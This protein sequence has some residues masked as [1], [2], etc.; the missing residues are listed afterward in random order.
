MSLPRMN[1]PG[2]RKQSGFSLV[3]LL[4][5]MVVGLLLL[6]GILEILLGNREGFE[7]QQRQAALQQNTR[8]ASFV[9]SNALAPTG[10]YVDGQRDENEVFTNAVIQ[11]TDGGKA[12]EPDELQI[13]FQAGG[14]LHNCLGAEIGTAT[15]AVESSFRYSLDTGNNELQCTPI[16]P[17]ASNAQPLV[18]NVENLQIEYGLDSDGDGSADRYVAADDALFDQARVVSLHLQLVLASPGDVLT[19]SRAQTLS[20]IGGSYTVTDRRQRQILD[21]TIALKNR[22]L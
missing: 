18:N 14:D 19:E 22:L 13:R 21:M 4:V 7:V 20:L 12:T 11:A 9:L 10:F 16:E 5:A 17:T 15:T 3:E 1:M 8:L 6:G 2:T